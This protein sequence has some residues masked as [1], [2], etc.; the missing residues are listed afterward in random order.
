MSKYYCPNFSLNQ[1]RTDFGHMS[2]VLGEDYAYYMWNK[3]KGLPLYLTEENGKEVPNKL[4]ENLVEKFGSTSKGMLAYLIQ[5]SSKFK[6]Q[7]P[8]F[9]TYDSNKQAEEIHKFINSGDQSIEE[10]AQQTINKLPKGFNAEYYKSA[11]RS[12]EA[13]V[14]DREA[15]RK[16]Q[17]KIAN[18][19]ETAEEIDTAKEGRRR[20]NAI[21]D[22]EDSSFITSFLNKDGKLTAF[23][24]F[25]LQRTIDEGKFA[26][27]TRDGIKLFQGSDF[28]DL[29]HESFHNFTQRYLSKDQRLALYSVVKNRPGTTQIGG[30]EVPYYSLTNREV[31]EVLAEEYRDFAISKREN[32]AEE[33][34]ARI[35]NQKT[36]SNVKDV[37][38]NMTNFFKA[39]FKKPAN[40]LEEKNP[41]A[42]DSVM[43]IFTDLYENN[44]SPYK[45]S[46]SNIT[47]QSIG[48]SKTIELDFTSEDGDVFTQEITGIE[49]AELFDAIDFWISREL[50]EKGINFS[51]LNNNEL[52]KQIIP[53]L[54]EAVK[55]NFQLYKVQIEDQ[56]DELGEE[57]NSPTAYT[58]KNRLLTIQWV[59]ADSESGNNWDKFV[60][61]HQSFSKGKIFNLENE[62]LE[63]QDIKEDSN[64]DETEVTRNQEN[65]D[66]VSINPE[67]LMSPTVLELLHR[68]PKI[69]K[70]GNYV[71]SPELGLPMLS[72]F[73][74]NK[75]LLLKRLSGL[76]D[77]KTI[78]ET[79]EGLAKYSPQF[80]Y[81]LEQL[82][83]PNAEVL[84]PEEQVLKN[85]FIQSLTMPNV[86]P[87]SVKVQKLGDGK[88]RK[89][90]KLQ[91]TTFLN[92]TLTT[93][94]LLEYF[95]QDFRENTNRRFRNLQGTDEVVR[96]NLEEAYAEYSNKNLNTD[97]LLF[98]FYYDMFGVDLIQDNEN[99]FDRKGTYIPNSVPYIN[100][101]VL[102][103]LRELGLHAYNKLIFSYKLSK[104]DKIEKSLKESMNFNNIQSPFT[105][106]ATDINKRVVSNVRK[107]DKD[108]NV[109]KY[110]EANFKQT[111]AYS[112]RKFVFDSIAY[113]YNDMESSS[114]LNE[115][116]N[117]EWS[118]RERNAVL[119]RR[120]KINTANDFSQLPGYLM[121]E[122]NP[123]VQFSIWAERMFTEDG[124]RKV[125]DNSQQVKLE[126]HNFS[127]FTVGNLGKK[128]TN[129]TPE[130]KFLQDFLSFLKD[131]VFENLRFGSK[132]TALATY[133]GNNKNDRIYYPSSL[134]IEEDTLV[135]GAVETQFKKY[136][137]F[138]LV[139]IFRNK[140]RK[141]R[142]EISASKINIFSDILK[143]T[144]VKEDLTSLALNATSEIE[145]LKQFNAN[146]KSRDVRFQVTFK[147]ALNEYFKDEVIKHKQNLADILTDGDLKKLPDYLSKVTGKE[148]AYKEKDLDLLVAYYVQN[149]MTH[150]IEFVHFMVADPSN[151]KTKGSNW[152]EVF[153]RLGA[154]ISPGKEPIID[155]QDLRSRNSNPDQA[156]KIEAVF[157]NGSRLHTKS[158][159][160]VVFED[161]ETFN[162]TNAKDAENTKKVIRDN[163][164]E[165]YAEYLATEEG[166]K[167]VTSK[168]RE[169]AEQKIGANV[170]AILKQDS[171]SDAQA[172]TT[173]DFIRYYLDSIGEWLP[174]QEEA[175]N[176]EVK[177][178]MAIKEYR[179]DKSAENLNKVEA[180]IN[181]A[182]AG[183]I[184]TLK[185]GHYSEVESKM[186]ETFL[187][188][189]SV[190]PLLPS[191]VFNTDLEERMI[192]MYESEVDFIMSKSAAK[193]SQPGEII[194]Q[195]V[196][197][198]D[199]YAV[200]KITE[201]S[202]FTLP[203]DGLRRQQYLAPKFKNKST[204][205]SQ[206]VK[207]LFSDFYVD[208]GFNPEFS[209]VPGLKNAIENAQDKFKN[210]LERLVEAEKARILV[211]IGAQLDSNGN[212]K[213][214]DFNKFEKW[215]KS[216]FD[217]KEISPSLYD[218]LKS[219][220]AGFAFSLD[221]SPQRSII[222]GIIATAIS[223]RIVRPKIFGE[224]YVQIASS[225]F[226]KTGTRYKKLTKDNIKDVMEEFGVTG[227][228]RDYRVENGVTMPADV[229][230]TFNPAKHAP[231]LELEFEG[232]RIGNI[233]KLNDILLGNTQAKKDWVEANK[234]KITIVGVRIPVQGFN[235]MEY[236]Q[237]R[238]FLPT[239][240]GPVIIVPPS[241]VTKSGSDFDID[242][243]F[244]YE[245][246][247]TEEGE[248]LQDTVNIEGDK[249]S[250]YN[251]I[252]TRSLAANKLNELSSILKPKKERALALSKLNA[253]EKQ[254]YE[255]F[256]G[257]IKDFIDKSQTEKFFENFE[258]EATQLRLKILLLESEQKYIMDSLY[259]DNSV[260]KPLIEEAKQIRNIFNEFYDY[261]SDKI[262]N[263]SSNEIIES[264]TTVLS[265]A[266]LFPT[267]TRPNNSDILKDLAE[268]YDEL[269][270]SEGKVTPTSMY[271]P[272]ISN[273][274]YR[275]ITLAKKS[276]SIDAKT[277]A[278][279]KLYQQAGLKIVDPGLVNT[280]LLNSH[281]KNNA[282]P[283]GNYY[284]TD[285][286]YKISDMID[287]LLNGHVDSENEEWVN[288]FNAD[289]AR[290]PIILQ[291]LLNGTSIDHVLLAINQP[292]I[293]HYLIKTK[294]SSVKRQFGEKPISISEYYKMILNPLG[295]DIETNAAGVFDEKATLQNIVN[296]SGI[297][298]AI[299][300]FNNDTAV[301][302]TDKIFPPEVNNTKDNFET[303]LKG[304]DILSLY[305][306][307]AMFSQYRNASL[308][309]AVLLD[310]NTAIDFNTSK[311]QNVNDFYI[312]QSKIDKA[313]EI[314]N[315]EGLNNI[316]NSSVVSPFN[317]VDLGLDLFK[318][319]FDIVN[320]P[321]V[322]KTI[323]EFVEE[324]GKFWT[325]NTTVIEKTNFLNG[326][327]H[328][329]IQKK[330]F[331]ENTT[332][333]QEYGPVSDYLTKSYNPNK[334][335]DL[336]LAKLKQIDDPNLQ[337]FL[338]NNL[339]FRNLTYSEI[340]DS[341]LTKAS[342]KDPN[343]K[344]QYNKMYF[345]VR[346]N[347]KDPD[348]V[349]SLQKAWLEAY[350]YS[351][352]S[353]E[354]NKQ[355]SDFVNDLAIAT[356][357]GQGYTIKYRSLQPFIP[358]SLLPL[359]GT[360]NYFQ[361]LKKRLNSSNPLVVEEAE[362]ELSMDLREFVGFYEIAFDKTKRK[363]YTQFRKNFPDYLAGKRLDLTQLNISA[364][365]YG[366]AAKLAPDNQ[367]AVD[368]NRL[369]AGINLS[370]NFP[371]KKTYYTLEKGKVKNKKVT[372]ETLA[373]YPIEFEGKLYDDIFTAYED[374]KSSYKI[375]NTEVKL[376][377]NLLTLRFE[378]Y[379]QLVMELYKAGGIDLLKGSGFS[380]LK[381]ALWNTVGENKYMEVLSKAYED[382]VESMDLENEL[383]STDD[384]D[385]DSV[386]DT[387]AELDESEEEAELS[388]EITSSTKAI[389]DPVEKILT[390]FS[391]EA[392][393][394]M[395]MVNFK[396]LGLNPLQISRIM[397]EIC[398]L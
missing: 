2:S 367:K 373:A 224:A 346:T 280:Y 16:K 283:L 89:N 171:E 122:N 297:R 265:Q 222:E 76:R 168:H 128:T 266:A 308:Q 339:L 215:L 274:L 28:T 116:G 164:I 131:G 7:H 59:L 38:N 158:Y 29:Y 137:Q 205:S 94:S 8:K 104:S 55:E 242:K 290:T 18:Q 165:S 289:K 111:T 251:K 34:L 349:A 21:I 234:K 390:E 182:N 195:Y 378:T 93:D 110:F 78:I 25:N 235:S 225:G 286:K 79:I 245:P 162:P 256:Y 214:V 202:K 61:H 358:V 233:S 396:A 253:P 394:S 292:I 26:E 179:K 17:Q 258:E 309:N 130:E 135:P 108:N 47:E 174:E 317:V 300:E 293:H 188:K 374:N 46:E 392:L 12:E 157:G 60:K 271:L 389:T 15:L 190:L 288:H 328:S 324:Y 322:Q 149:Y 213:K 154:S 117:L 237:V 181:T 231:L 268:K 40:E 64:F 302:L 243:L 19:T 148:T 152:R 391:R 4:Y 113:L 192:D 353:P 240:S 133:V 186:D 364:Q 342:Y 343:E 333:Y 301:R 307:V 220:S 166:K 397:E 287:Q 212:I 88:D 51:F 167:K 371:N 216:E 264:F 273:T 326:F 360:I 99:M 197:T 172:Y 335:L 296:N 348:T 187:G 132:N 318:N 138:E 31:E 260:L 86:D 384:I 298:R 279:H 1:T 262:K 35:G 321:Y 363:K 150:Q 320:N 210:S 73:K 393:I 62:T 226:N 68:L 170:D 345:R 379:P 163:Y 193:T 315:E 127:G 314:F 177:V 362:L 354:V 159:N 285:G 201:K 54:Y 207:L 114:Y 336:R 95:D 115:E 380:G 24:L 75:N 123:F 272:R 323:S 340:P 184:N 39:F 140:D 66:D 136:L 173:V 247:L 199:G 9:N 366:L 5:N 194:K 276:L 83:D 316:I 13:L 103:N 311:Y 134:Y 85:Q 208:G 303:I 388:Q 239:S 377:E 107:L 102:N 185:L 382:V 284:D 119:S 81:L 45:K 361:E 359:D 178:A 106:F 96:F 43:K 100:N 57:D 310:L 14:V 398:K 337:A 368:L 305:R 332:L 209:K 204:L 351:Y 124:Q 71:Y 198:P 282:L 385:L 27:W 70:Q 275:E 91:T 48:R 112:Q 295:I 252:R 49:V 125:G 143:D 22:Y 120:D 87:Y 32:E 10:L 20:L 218:Y 267:L 229:A 338:K 33:D 246:S 263:V 23:A 72:D 347:E 381:D 196:E 41:M 97:K 294:G 344:K 370:E 175:Y 227:L 146:Y 69:D 180:L 259:Y 330:G 160:A 36:E 278:L 270:S 230:I 261:T 11:G 141:T 56:L 219:N 50:E 37:F 223:K 191:A 144:K 161:I 372:S 63:D 58:L 350:N 74:A 44:V 82:P 156:K 376:M 147:N 356:I 341:G 387:L 189:F 357:M 6:K 176:H 169:L 30:V 325:S 126:V 375:T 200:N 241:I 42:S 211:N 98:E 53:K 221:A 395:S 331:E 334:S 238:K 101:T 217:K 249:S 67:Q 145:L 329:I 232:K 304:D 118:I 291:M 250:L 142:K 365:G 121:P 355:V 244:M 327:I 65:W 151:Y 155:D 383:I 105:F 84:T 299:E 313:R 228:L 153:K 206:L 352:G 369:D 319:V 254:M 139:R 277:N 255:A 248:L 269:R 203:M 3:N 306:Q 281:K 386:N 77:Y 257:Q 109:R 236:F 312:I 90:V 92:N 183:I 129:L 80:Y 52:R